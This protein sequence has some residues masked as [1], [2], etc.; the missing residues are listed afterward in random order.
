MT[1]LGT[2]PNLCRPVLGPLAPPPAVALGCHCAQSQSPRTPMTKLQPMPSRRP[3]PERRPLPKRSEPLR[4]NC[5]TSRLRMPQS[6]RCGEAPRSDPAGG[7]AC[8]G[9]AA[10]PA[11]HPPRR[12]RSRTSFQRITRGTTCH[13]ALRRLPTIQFSICCCIVCS[14]SRCVCDSVMFFVPA[15]G[16]TTGH[17]AYVEPTDT[18]SYHDSVQGQRILHRAEAG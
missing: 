11:Y 12:N 14:V 17:V 2:R 7:A 9:Q 1:A 15:A 10:P 6:D 3:T 8:A 13:T 4:G 18:L 16:A 5:G